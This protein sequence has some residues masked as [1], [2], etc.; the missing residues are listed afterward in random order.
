MRRILYLL[1]LS[2]VL[3]CHSCSDDNDD[4]QIETQITLDQKELSFEELGGDA[5]VEL[6]VNGEWRVE[7]YPDWLSLSQTSGDAASE[8]KI[9]AKANDKASKRDAQL[10]FAGKGKSVSLD[11]IQDARGA[12]IS[13][14][15]LS[16]SSF[17]RMGYELGPDNIERRYGFA[18]REIFIAPDAASDIH[19]KLFLGNLVN[20]KLKSN[21]DI[22]EYSGYT[23]NPITV[24]TMVN[25]IRS[26]SFTPSKEEQDAY[27]Q[28]ILDSKPSQSEYLF[29]DNKGVVYNSHRE[30]N[31]IGVGNMGV[32]LD[33]V[34]SGKPYRE[35]E[36]GKR[37]GVIFS[38]DQ[39]LFSLDMDLQQWIVEEEIKPED[40][41]DG[42][43]SYISTVS[44]GRMGMLIVESDEDVTTIRAIVNKIIG[45]RDS[46]LTQEESKILKELDAHHLYYNS[47]REL[48]IAKGGS[49]VIKAYQQ[50]VTE[51]N[52]ELFLYKF[53]V[54][55]YF[56]RYESEMTF[57][58]TIR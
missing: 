20:N 34:I 40:F 3:I 43:L 41:P 11:I 7:N 52:Q 5:T 38:F 28:L 49:E 42:T 58:L 13:W 19:N 9:A 35:Q 37:N 32:E 17:H 51:N 22:E 25:S 14:S 1:V 24:S 16:F 56:E 12:E 27:V 46:E 47:S 36:M 30:L 18:T 44:Y 55:D 26:K 8:I 10:V 53:R 54:T 6:T 57:A 45:G 50:Q 29:I 39:T 15:P 48:H 31:L 21:R 4:K 33:K 2:S 23:F